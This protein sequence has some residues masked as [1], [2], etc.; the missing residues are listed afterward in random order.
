MELDPLLLARIQ[1]AF[2]ISFHILFPS[3]TIGLASWL[4]VL[5]A[6]WLRTGN[7]TYIRLYRFWV[8]LFAVSFGMGVVS[9][10]VMSYQEW[11]SEA[12]PPIVLLHDIS[13]CTHAFDEPSR[14]AEGSHMR[15]VRSAPPEK[16]R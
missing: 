12:S 3:F 2:T 11:G 1:F 10:I 6:Q 15:T 14:P 8:K 13:D 7:D 16:S 9:G 5:E 4:A